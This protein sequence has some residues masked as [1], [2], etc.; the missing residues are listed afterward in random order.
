MYADDTKIFRM[1]KD[2]SDETALQKDLDT[3]YTWT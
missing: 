3:I 2:A 1:I